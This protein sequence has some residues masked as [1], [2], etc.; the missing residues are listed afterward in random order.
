MN[1]ISLNCAVLHDDELVL[2]RMEGYI[3]KVP[4]LTLSGCY[5]SPMEALHAYYERH[6]DV[7]FVGLHEVEESAVSGMDFA[8][9]LTSSTRV[10]FLADTDQYAATCFRLDALDYLSGDVSFSIFSQAV[11]KAIRWF[12][13]QD[14]KISMPIKDKGNE[15][16]LICV[17]ADNKILL[18]NLS[19]I[20][21]MEGC[22]DYVKV[23]TTDLDKSVF[24]PM[25]ILFG[26]TVRLLC[27]RN[28]FVLLVIMIYYW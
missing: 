4:F 25:R 23:F 18:L 12:A 7:Y 19:N 10:I 26:Y 13:G 6:V 17:R 16:S 9:L 5:T 11:F 28:L 24:C 8:R 20:Y 15:S 27:R 2:Q 1:E 14:R 21:C 22:G 3:G